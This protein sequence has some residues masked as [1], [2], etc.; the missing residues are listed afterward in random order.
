MLTFP[1][2]SLSLQPQTERDGLSIG[3]PPRPD[4]GVLRCVRYGGVFN[5]TLW[6]GDKVESRYMRDDTLPAWL[7]G[8]ANA[9][10]L[11]GHE[12]H[13]DGR[14]PTAYF[15]CEVDVG[16]NLIRFFDRSK[17]HVS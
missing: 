10:K 4:V 16:R 3:P 1:K 11:G 9:A 2:L 17:P 12:Q 7:D 13:V 8:I 5:Y 14:P 6:F 15:W